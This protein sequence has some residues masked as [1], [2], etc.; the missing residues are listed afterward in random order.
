MRGDLLP[1]GVF[2]RGARRLV[3]IAALAA[4][5]IAG[6]SGRALAED[7]DEDVTSKIE[8]LFREAVD[9]FEIG[10]YNE[11]RSRLQRV[12]ELDPKAA[13]AWKLVKMAGDLIIIQMMTEADMGREA[14]VIWELYRLHEMR[15]KRQPDLIKRL[16]AMAIDPQKHPRRRWDA[17]E[18]LTEV[19]QFVIPSLVDALGNELDHQVRA[20]ASLTARKMGPQATLPVIELL[21]YRPAEGEVDKRSRLIRENAALILGDLKDKRALAALKRVAEVEKDSVLRKYALMSLQRITGLSGVEELKSAQDYYYLQADRYLRELA[22]VADEAREA[23]GVIW[24][25]ELVGGVLK[26]VDRQVPRFAWNELMAE[27]ACYDCMSVDPNYEVIYPLFAETIASQIAELWELLDIALERPVGRPFTEEEV[28]DVKSREKKL[29]VEDLSLDSPGR[30]YVSTTALKVPRLPVRRNLLLSALGPVYVY[31]AINK[32]LGDARQDERELPKLAAIVLCDA[33]HALDPD[34]R[35]LPKPGRAAPARKGKGR[36]APAAGLAEGAP[37]I[38]A[39]R[40]PDERVRYAAAI[41][42]AR[43]NPPQPFDGAEDV[44]AVLAR[45]IGESGALQVLLVVEDPSIRNE[46]KGKLQELDIGITVADTAR[47]A[48]E[49]AIGFPPP[50]VVLISPKLEKNGNARWLLESLLEDPRSR[51]MPAAIITS[52]DARD[53]DKAI[54]RNNENVKGYVPIEDTG[55]ELRELIEKVASM[56]ATPI[57]S[58]KRSEELSVNAAEAL[59]G[60]NP[61][62]ARINGMQIEQAAEACIDALANRRDAVRRPCIDALG[63]FGIARAHDKLV[64]LLGDQGQTLDIRVAAGRAVSLITPEAGF[65]RLLE[66]ADNEQEKYILRYLAAEGLGHASGS[67]EKVKETLDIL[68]LPLE[69]KPAMQEAEAAEEEW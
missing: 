8:T 67:P 4:P 41:S 19:G 57:M 13:E 66:M 33:A 56:R 64:E 54:F 60:I 39:L 12:L 44:V 49:R 10:K 23:D 43:M 38:E 37:L 3:L 59:C 2:S 61:H 62:L 21:K 26:L 7:L 50:D 36:G 35:L 48:A 24:R 34:G 22:G 28:T 25:L 31:R 9:L 15:L 17:M 6:F 46:L 20:L 40:F 51:G 18:R 14:R 53:E 65:A 16:V 11:S 45:A 63:R 29:L 47:D 27:Q 32:C 42:L 52:Y 69:G 1:G 55:K 58:K 30:L 5:A 68:R